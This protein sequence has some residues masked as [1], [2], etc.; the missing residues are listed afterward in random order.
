MH[1]PN[2]EDQIKALA[3]ENRILQ[4]QLDRSEIDRAH[5]EEVHE[6]RQRVLKQAAIES[7]TARRELEK[8]FRNL[9][10]MENKMSSLGMLIAG[11]AHEI[12]NPLS[13]VEG[14]LQPA[15]DYCQDLLALIDLFC[16]QYRDPDAAI[17]AKMRSIDLNYVKH[18]LPALLASMEHGIERIRQISAS[19]R[20][21]ARADVERPIKT[22]LHDVLESAL[23]IL[24][25]RCK[26]TE[27]C[28]AITLNRQYADLPMIACYPGPLSQV[29]INL[30]GNAIDALQEHDWS[31]DA[32]P[33]ITITTL[34]EADVVR[35]AIADNGPGIPTDVIDQIFSPT[36]TTKAVGK[37]TGLG[38]AIA[39]EIIQDQH[40]GTLT[41]QSQPGIGTTFTITLAS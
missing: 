6:K 18:D 12:N 36:F 17:Q 25:H 15:A 27:N 23:L 11:V 9:Q 4:R 5:L 7:E 3:K 20:I 1:H 32:V 31:H 24:K 34:E 14:N 35:V 10:I 40:Q 19:L 16:Q 8:A 21:V 30:V 29:I 13:F 41:C 2:P 33:C 26:A 38:L 28:P 22:D 39:K 37:G